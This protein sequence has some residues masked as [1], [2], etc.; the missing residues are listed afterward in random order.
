M[1][2]NSQYANGNRAVKSAS[3]CMVSE[4]TVILNKILSALDE[5]YVTVSTIKKLSAHYT[6]KQPLSY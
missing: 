4:Y 6:N 2:M 1:H 3:Q 5:E